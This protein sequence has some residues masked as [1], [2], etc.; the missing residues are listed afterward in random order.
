MPSNF[1]L[2]SHPVGSSFVSS[3]LP[4][5]MM[6]GGMVPLSA[7][8]PPLVVGGLDALDESELD[9]SEPDDD[10]PVTLVEW[11]KAD[12]LKCLKIKLKG[13]NSV[14]TIKTKTD[15]Y[16]VLIMKNGFLLY[17]TQLSDITPK[18]EHKLP[19]SEREITTINMLITDF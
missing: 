13:N 6:R 14:A 2:S 3:N 17:E 19:K 8:V 9:G 16:K 11:I 10:Y 15:F 12:G 5:S 18:E 7:A 1:S 4:A